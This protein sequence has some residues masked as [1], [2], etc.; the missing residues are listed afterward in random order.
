MSSIASYT[1]FL[2][3]L[4]V[5]TKPV[6]GILRVAD[7]S[8]A[9]TNTLVVLVGWAMAKQKHVG[10]YSDVYNSLGYPALTLVPSLL[11]TW[12]VSSN[13]KYT[14]NVMQTLEGSF[15]ATLTHPQ[16]QQQQQKLSI[17]LHMFSGSSSILLPS[18]SLNASNF[19]SIEL[20]G[21]V[22]DCSP[23]LY[24]YDSGMAAAKMVLDDG[25]MNI[26]T[27]YVSIACGITIDKLNGNRKRQDLAKALERPLLS[28][29]QLY[30]HS[31]VD[32]VTPYDRVKGIMEEQK[33]L[34]RNVKGALFKGARHVRLLQ[35][36]PDK[37]TQQIESF[38]QRINT[39][40]Q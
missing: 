12:D 35:S 36:E 30:L 39:R 24:G 7:G 40:V 25:G 18:L 2:R 28:V 29:P 23:P 5:R 15:A 20:K 16:Q 26:F 1:K 11:H 34:G 8:D 6:R 37:Y 32:P 21:I 14:Q 27:Y 17:I 33:G 4:S 22:F 3:H 19:E 38:L 10:K 31:D 13:D 9:N